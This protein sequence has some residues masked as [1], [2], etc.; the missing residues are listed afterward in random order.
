MYMP[1]LLFLFVIF[2]PK[3]D[4]TIKKSKKSKRMT[5]KIGYDGFAVKRNSPSCYGKKSSVGVWQTAVPFFKLK[6]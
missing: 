6:L 1:N 5:T 4:V 2:F 3:Y